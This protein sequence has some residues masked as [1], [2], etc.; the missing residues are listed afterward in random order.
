MRIHTL[1]SL[2]LLSACGC[3]QEAPKTGG[4]VKPG[5]TT[6]VAA[7]DTSTT[8]ETKKVPV[9]APPAADNSAVNERDKTGA[10]KTPIDQN[11]NQ[12]DIQITAD[13]RKQVVDQADFSVSARNVKIITADGKVTLRGPVT[14]EKERDVIV[15]IAEEVAGKSNVDS[16]LEI[17]P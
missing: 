7:T 8:V 10:T 4:T 6:A 17:T 14:T 1:V 3:V 2:G 11:E 12:K 13:I 16:Q 9:N 15:K 5:D